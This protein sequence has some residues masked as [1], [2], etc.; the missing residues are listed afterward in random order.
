MNR[1]KILLICSAIVSIFLAGTI[2]LAIFINNDEHLF[3]TGFGSGIT[4]SPDDKRI[5]FSY[6]LKGD[7]AIYSAKTDG[8][9]VVKLANEKNVRFHSPHY[10][11]DGRRL[12]FLGAKKEGVNSLYILNIEGTVP[13]KINTSDLHI[14][15]AVFSISDNT[16]FFTAMEGKEYKKTEEERRGGYDL[17]SVSANGGTLKKLTN[18]NYFSLNSLM[19]SSDGE[20]LLYSEF[21]SEHE[22]LYSLSLKDGSIKKYPIATKLPPN[23]YPYFYTLSPNEEKMAFTSYTDG[24]NHDYFEYELYLANVHNGQTEKLTDLHT[25]VEFPQFFHHENKILFLENTNWPKR[26]A[27]FSLKTVD[28]GTKNIES[29]DLKDEKLNQRHPFANWLYKAVNIYMIA[30]L[31]I[32]LLCLLSAY[33]HFGKGKPYRVPLVSFGLAISLFIASFAASALYNPWYGMGLGML[34]AGVVVC[35]GAAFL[36]AFFLSKISQRN[37]SS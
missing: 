35:T 16:I 14:Q 6:Y 25:S 5:A 34:A 20:Y 9:E 33:S 18:N 12:L 2:T 19:A 1:G 32:L 30:A 31:Y 10:S 3:F 8:S 24:E 21:G 23:L 36:M 11:H 17:Y 28:I 13:N 27:R 29:I 22:E 7:E 15:R 37:N 4:V 26:P